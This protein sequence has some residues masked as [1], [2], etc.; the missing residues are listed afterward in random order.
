MCWRSLQGVFYANK[1]VTICS[2]Y[3]QLYNIEKGCIIY[4]VA[5]VALQARIGACEELLPNRVD[6]WHLSSLTGAF[7]F[8]KMLDL[9]EK[10][11]ESGEKLCKLTTLP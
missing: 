2:Q 4:T 9:K 3:K 6:W 5:A 8:Q 10:S 1:N 11:K 7:L